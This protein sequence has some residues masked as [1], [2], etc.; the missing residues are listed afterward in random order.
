MSTGKDAL[1]IDLYIDTHLIFK[2]L[3]FHYKGIY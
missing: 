3:S 1:Q 2:N